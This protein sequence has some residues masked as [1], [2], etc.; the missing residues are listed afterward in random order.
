VAD[1]WDRFVS[2][3]RRERQRAR[4]IGFLGRPVSTARRGRKGD[5]LLWLGPPEKIKLG[6]RV[7]E[8]ASE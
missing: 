7:A 5:G 6:L 1:T 3:L 2:E 8:W 4:D